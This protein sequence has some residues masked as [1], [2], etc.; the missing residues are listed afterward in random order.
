[1]HPRE[2]GAGN[3][4]PHRLRAAGQQ[5]RAIAIPAAVRQA[6]LA[7]AGIDRGHPGAEL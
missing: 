3:G 6:D 2:I 7:V 4:E 1:M 5:Q